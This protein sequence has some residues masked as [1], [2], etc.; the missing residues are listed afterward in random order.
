MHRAERWQILWRFCWK[1]SKLVCI[2]VISEAVVRI[3]PMIRREVILWTLVICDA[4]PLAPLPPVFLSLP[5]VRISEH[6]MS[7]VYNILGRMT[8]LKS[9]HMNFPFMPLVILVILLQARV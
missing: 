3:P 5:F 9:F 7:A 4:K 1:G 8:L 6:Q 2:F